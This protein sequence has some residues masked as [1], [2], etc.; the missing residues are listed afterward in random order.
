MMYEDIVQNFKVFFPTQNHR[1]VKWGSFLGFILV[2]A[3]VSLATRNYP[4]K[5]LYY[6]IF[7]VAFNA[8]LFL[9]MRVFLG[10]FEIFASLFL[11]MG[12]WLKLSVRLALNNLTFVEAVGAFDNSGDKFDQVL[13]VS[14]TACLAILVAFIGK[15]KISFVR[16]TTAYVVRP[17]YLKRRNVILGLFT[18]FFVGISI[19]NLNFGFYQRG[20]VPRTILPFG[21]NGIFSWLLQFGF[22]SIAVTIIHL[23][24]LSKR[25][26]FGASL[27][28]FVEVFFSNVSLLSRGFILN[29]SSILLGLFREARVN[30]SLSRKF[31]L[32]MSAFI[33]FTLSLLT[34]SSLRLKFS[35]GEDVRSISQVMKHIK[36][37]SLFVD[38]WVGIEGVMAVVSYP[39]KGWDLWKTAW[40]EKENKF[41]T[42]FYDRVIAKSVYF[43]DYSDEQLAQHHVVTLPGVIAL[44]YYP[45]SI[46]F[47]VVISFLIF[48]VCSLFE[49]LIFKLTK[50]NLLCALIGQ[51]IA[52]RLAS[53]GYVPGQSYK[54]F[55]TIVINIF[56]LSAIQ[57]VLAKKQ[58]DPL[59]T[60]DRMLAE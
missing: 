13:L 8:L 20:A 36:N 57:R 10:Y 46:L 19:L 54:F 52:F 31:V 45:G 6:L 22:A 44:L 59:I 35:S 38:R 26:A 28:A 1:L 23:D 5:A 25:S 24:V 21:L 40:D 60:Q 2:L 27:L 41:G 42:S 18:L 50:N 16:D 15:K 39:D 53:T 48:F 58:N 33:L 7:S 47:L 56:L 55:G 37:A 34:V 30:L 17:V 3:L 49:E 29:A 11:W 12:F 9:S 51:C 14:T 43:T 32:A 4:G